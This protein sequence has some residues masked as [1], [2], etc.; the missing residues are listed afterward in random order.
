MKDEE[1]MS[2]AD[3]VEIT[4]FYFILIMTMVSVEEWV[5]WRLDLFW[6]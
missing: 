3:V 1:K 6:G 4:C 5:V 2:C